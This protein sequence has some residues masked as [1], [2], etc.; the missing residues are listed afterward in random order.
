[1]YRVFETIKVHQHRVFNLSYHVE[2]M[3]K[4]AAFLSFRLPSLN[5]LEEQIASN[6][7]GETAHFYY[8]VEELTSFT[9][10]HWQVDV[11][12]VLVGLV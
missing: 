4:T 12:D 5:H 2:R 7:F 1:M 6:L 3:K 9:D 10:L 8:F 11:L